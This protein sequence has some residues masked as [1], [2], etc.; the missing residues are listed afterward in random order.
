[1]QL[2]S[3]SKLLTC[4]DGTDFPY[5]AETVH[6]AELFEAVEKLFR[7]ELAP[8]IGNEVTR[9]SETLDGGLEKSEDGLC[10]WF[11][12]EDTR[13][14]WKAGETVQNDGELEAPKSEEAGNLG[15]VD[16][17]DM[18]GISRT[19][20]ERS[21]RSLHLSGTSVGRLF[22]KNAPD[23]AFGELPSCASQCLGDRLVSAEAGQPHAVDEL[24]DDI[25]VATERGVVYHFNP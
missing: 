5:G 7:D 4:S 25:G 12:Q 17:G 10:G 14:E 21:F 11:L 18:V 22:P 1:M 20:G 9:S 8:L 13:G 19:H 3:V 23:G 6:D 24:T 16:E 15:D 2:A